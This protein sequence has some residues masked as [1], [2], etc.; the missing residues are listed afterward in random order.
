MPARGGRGG[1]QFRYR[2]AWADQDWARNSWVSYTSGGVTVGYVAPVAILAGSP[3]PGVTNSLWEQ[4]ISS[5]VTGPVGPR[6][7]TGNANILVY[8]RASSIPSLPTDGMWDGTTLT[9]PVGYSI[10]TPTG[11]DTL[12]ALVAELD[13]AN[14]L[15]IAKV[16]FQAQ[17]IPGIQGAVGLASTVPGPQGHAGSGVALLFQRSGTTPS[18]PTDGMW[19]G[20]AITLPSGWF[21]ADPDPASSENLWMLVS[22]LDSINNAFDPVDIFSAQGIPGPRGASAPQ[23]RIQY[24]NDDGVTYHNSPPSGDTTNLQLSTDGGANYQPFSLQQGPQGIGLPGSGSITLF[25]RAATE[26]PV[27]SDGAWDGTNVTLPADWAAGDPDPHSTAQLWAL[28]VILDSVNGTFT[29]ALVFSAQGVGGQ[30]APLPRSQYS[31]NNSSW[32]ATQALTDIYKR[33]SNDGGT[34]YSIGYRIIG[35][36]GPLPRSQ[37][38]VDNATWHDTLVVDDLYKRDSNDNGV[39]WSIGY[40]IVGERGQD[41]ASGGTGRSRGSRIFSTT[42]ALPTAP[43]NTVF[44]SVGFMLNGTQP[45][46]SALTG[47]V[48]LPALPPL[49]PDNVVTGMWL[50]LR[51]DNTELSV[52]KWN[53]GLNAL[54]GANANSKIAHL[55]DP[56]PGQTNIGTIDVNMTLSNSGTLALTLHGNDRTLRPNLYVD[57][58]YAVNAGGSDAGSVINVDDADVTGTASV[59]TLDIPGITAYADNMIVSFQFPGVNHDA[60]VALKIGSLTSYEMVKT[61][62]L[63]FA[64][65]E[66]EPES[67]ILARL[68]V[69]GS[70]WITNVSA[71][72]ST[73]F[74]HPSDVTQSANGNN[75]TLAPEY[76]QGA[77]SSIAFKFKVKVPNTGPITMTVT[78]SGIAATSL[79][80]QDGSEYAANEVPVNLLLA[81]IYDSG[82]NYWITSNYLPGSG[83]TDWVSGEATAVGVSVFD[84]ADGTPFRCIIADNGNNGPP[85]GDNDNFEAWGAGELVE[86]DVEETHNET[87]RDVNIEAAHLNS[88][89]QISGMLFNIT[90]EDPN[91]FDITVADDRAVIQYVCIQSP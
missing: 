70:Q 76:T 29:P 6:G 86:T 69:S 65:A 84:T 40:K 1:Q 39:T 54:I 53:W 62:L 67:W 30:D 87:N 77:S 33:D 64:A 32:H 34:T 43:N 8:I 14:D 3:A 23:V 37:Y 68:D 21:R 74:V 50:V 75:I 61:D 89:R 57:A 16:H 35:Q 80:R 15:F 7:N 24:S 59:V 83:I 82:N 9:V 73:I 78:D 36:R 51:E 17:G 85:S 11:T 25:R 58:Y 60:N 20:S 47:A 66:L 18:L 44:G 90:V 52:A 13:S 19:D 22:I 72:Y 31:V 28:Y 79:R 5:V 49:S 42:V 46:F 41:S 4:L 55:Y 38:S 88:L 12:F 26:P 10:T 45:G 91:F 63:G 81:M 71:D 56:T 27:P 2:G 48:V